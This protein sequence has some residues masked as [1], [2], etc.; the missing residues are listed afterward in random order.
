M[1]SSLKLYLL[2]VIL[3]SI[4][5]TFGCEDHQARYEDPPWLGGSNIETLEERGNYTIFL[6]LMEKANYTEPISKQLFTLFVPDD[7]AFMEYF[8]SAGI[9]SV[10][11]LTEDQAVQLF[12]LHVLRNPRS[13]FYLIY[14]YAWSEF[15]G[16]K[17]EY[18]SLYHR[19]VTPSTSIPY[20][21]TVRYVPGEEGNEYLIYT[22]EKCVPLFSKEFFNDFGSENPESDYTFM[23]PGST[24]EEGYSANQNGMNWHNAMV[25]PDPENPAGLEVRTSSGFIYLLD[26]VVSPMPSVEE[27]LIDNQD[28]FGLYYDLLQRFAQYGSQMVDEQRRV[29]YK[30]QYDLVFNIAHEGGPHLDNDPGTGSAKRNMWTAFLPQDELLQNYLDNTVLQYYEAIDSIPRIT[31]FYILQGQLSE[32]MVLKSGL[33]R[34]YFNAFGDPQDFNSSDLISGYMCSNGV[35][36][37]TTKV[38]EPNVF[39]TVPGTLFFDKNYSTLLYVMN[40]ANMLSSLSNPDSDVTVFVTTNEALEAYGIRYNAAS[41]VVEFRGPIDGTWATMKTTDL[42]IFAQ[43]Q[44]YQGLI[45]DLDGSEGFVEMSSKNYIQ[46]GNNKVAGGE[47]QASNT[48][49]NIEEIVVN[50]ENGLLVKVDRPIGTRVAMGQLVDNGPNSAVD[51]EDPDYSEFKDL[52]LGMNL[53]SYAQ[54]SVTKEVIPNIKFLSSSD[55]WTAF[56]PTNAA[57]A[58]A[59]LDGILPDTIP[60]SSE[61]KDSLK[62][63]INYHFIKG[64]VIFDDGLRS[65]YYPTSYTYIDTT[66]NSTIN[67]PI[68]VINQLN[69]LSIE[70]NTGQ[71]VTVTHGSANRLVQKGVIHKIDAILR[72]TE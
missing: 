68:R 45:D 28:K 21:E 18:A 5:G 2:P 44:I 9:D 63:F 14:E 47:N 66:D 26:R 49:A 19:K 52:L 23:Y 69:N 20:K 11:D 1:K 36:Y 51:F 40:Q 16:P 27:Y 17:G 64:S 3:I 6:E 70:D 33:D 39:K 13:R 53:M 7:D 62:N 57:I 58:Q 8:E 71:I 72:Y 42:I 67:E 10:G 15:Q 29:L 22:D 32:R 65:G 56:I 50:E 31:L 4:L 24:W 37:E 59:R 12:T 41:D 60:E 61:G 48:Y 25:I 43:D 34:G 38:L 46:Y 35:V 30:K 54:N 55:Y